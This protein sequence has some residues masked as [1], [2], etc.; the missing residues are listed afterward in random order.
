MSILA[1]SFGAQSTTKGIN[2]LSFRVVEIVSFR[3]TKVRALPVVELGGGRL[4]SGARNHRRFPMDVREYFLIIAARNRW[5]KL[6]F[7]S[8]PFAAG[9]WL[10]A[11]LYIFS[12]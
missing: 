1:L 8:V 3:A 10:L 11:A 6:A 9:G 7:L 2:S 4:P 12:R 5:R